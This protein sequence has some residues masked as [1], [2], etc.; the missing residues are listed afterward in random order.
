MRASR[1]FRPASRSRSVCL[2][3]G[4]ML[5][6]L[7]LPARAQFGPDFRLTGPPFFV[8]QTAKNHAWSV[9]TDDAGNVHVIY[10]DTRNGALGDVPPFY[11][12]YDRALGAWDAEVRLPGFP[13][14]NARYVAIAADC[15][16]RVHVAWV[17]TVA[18][19]QHYLYYKQRDA[20]G[21]WGPDV[22]LQTHATD[23]WDVRDPSVA[24]D[25][26]GN[27]YVVWAEGLKNL[28]GDPVCNILYRVSDGSSWSG[29]SGITSYVSGVDPAPGARAPSV[30]AH[31]RLFGTGSIAH[32][33]WSDDPTGQVRYRAIRFV[34]GSGVTLRGTVN[35]SL[36]SGAAPPTVATRCGE[37]DVVWSDSGTGVIAHRHGE[38]TFTVAET[39]A[40][41]PP[42]ATG[43]VGETPSIAVDGLGNTE[44]AMRSG[45]AVVET[46]RSAMSGAWSAPTPVSDPGAVPSDPSIAV[47]T[48]GAAHV[49]WRDDRSIP[50]GSG[51]AYY[52]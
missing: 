39:T 27:V 21:A 5:V 42:A 19:D 24:A 23:T 26:L 34:P 22:V 31:H 16:G 10:F 35:V 32:V 9:A 3:A 28:Q 7:A 45:G 49:V 40:F 44:L 29:P 30:A 2:A 47:D 14:A 48:R 6:A 4:T 37:A 18:G 51:G 1:P 8:S 38:M 46:H 13:T 11:R 52:D 50:P 12:R 17:N 41:L 25:Y 20:T 15:L 43:L 36:G 33:A